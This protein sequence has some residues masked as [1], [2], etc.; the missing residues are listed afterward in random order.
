MSA[1][2]QAT[3]VLALPGRQ[4]VVDVALAPGATLGDAVRASGL[5]AQLSGPGPE[6]ELPP[7]GLFHRRRDPQ[8]PLREGDRIEIY[9]P[10]SID[11][12]EARRLRAASPRKSRPAGGQP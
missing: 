10:L 3:V 7:L 12:K 8:T 5:L 2:L 6:G 11:P 4:W 1:V 9:R